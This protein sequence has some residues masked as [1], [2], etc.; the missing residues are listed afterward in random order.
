L[1][2]GHT[3]NPLDLRAAFH[4]SSKKPSKRYR[5]DNSRHF[6]LND[7]D[8]AD[9]NSLEMDKER[10]GAILAQDIV[11]REAMAGT[12]LRPAPLGRAGDLSGD[13]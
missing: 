1:A 13:G 3:N 2:T 8:S 4:A 7:H 10:A 5:I 6:R 9:T 11:R 12:A